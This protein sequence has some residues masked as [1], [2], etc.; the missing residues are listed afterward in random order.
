MRRAA[1][2]DQN[3]PD[4]V[5]ALRDAGCGVLDL[6]AVG[7]GCPDLLV[8]PPTFPDCRMA[9]LM[10]IKNPKVRGKLNKRQVE[11]H[12]NW[13]GWIHTVTSVDEALL[14]MGLK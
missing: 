3:H 6:S 14:V 10:E 7:E 9:V 12:E 8:H 4:I 2:V 11:F 1:K 5:K 13:K